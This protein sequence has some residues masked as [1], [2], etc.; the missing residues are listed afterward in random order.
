MVV[1]PPP[2]VISS[3]GHAK[4]APL[5]P[6]LEARKV[7]PHQRLDIGV[8]AGGGETL[9]F[10]HLRRDLGRERHRHV[11]QSAD[12]FIA[13][14]ALVLRIGEAVQEADRDRLDLLRWRC[15]DCARARLASSSGTSTSALRIDPLADAARAGGAAPA[16]AAGRC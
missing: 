11:R 10:A 4:P 9:V 13:D 7:A 8:G 16:V 12:D 6:P 5:S 2:E 3:R 14:A 1:M 15:I